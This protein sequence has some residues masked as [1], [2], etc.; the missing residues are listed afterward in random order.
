MK[1]IAI[2]LIAMLAIAS[3]AFAANQVRISQ[4]YG[5]GGSSGSTAPLSTYQTDYIELFNSGGTPVNVGGWLLAYSSATGVFSATVFAL[6]ANTTIAPCSYLLIQCGSSGTTGVPVPSPDVTIAGGPSM[7][8]T[9]GKISLLSSGTAG[10]GSCPAGAVV[11]FVGFGTA[12]CAEGT[13]TASLARNVAAVRNNGGLTD[14]DVNSA[15]FTLVTA[16]VPH[17]S[18][19]PQNQGCL[20]T[21]SMKSSWGT[22][23]TLYR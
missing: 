11:D 16:P 6:P 20:A 3:S 23:K 13:A 14:T 12:N 10:T 1:K 21:P 2:T 8:A 18:A 4:V 9:D 15:D 7:S 22:L 5:G 19:S 17:N